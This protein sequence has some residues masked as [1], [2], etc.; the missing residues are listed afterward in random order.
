[1]YFQK[2]YKGKILKEDPHYQKKKF[3]LIMSFDG[4]QFDLKKPK[5]L[6]GLKI[7]FIL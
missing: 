1:L 5:V 7:H 4:K 2:D 6:K 3:F